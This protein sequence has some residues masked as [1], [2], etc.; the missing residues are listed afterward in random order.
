MMPLALVSYDAI[1]FLSILCDSGMLSMVSLL[2]IGKI[3]KMIHGVTFGHVT[4]LAPGDA[5]CIINE[6]T[7][8][9]RSRQLK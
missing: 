6:T 1:V 2:S 7:A 5:D 3:I 4:P 8:F 9:L